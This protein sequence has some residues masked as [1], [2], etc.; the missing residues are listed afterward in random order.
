VR[1]FAPQ[2]FAQLFCIPLVLFSISNSSAQIPKRASTQEQIQNREWALASLRRD[3]NAPQPAQQKLLTLRNDFRK[4]QVVNNELMAHMF[5]P[6]APQITQKEIRSSLDEIRRVAERLRSNFGLPRI[7]A[8]EPA[9]TLE[10]KPGLLQLDKAVVSFVEN[11]LFEQTKV[12]D[13]ELAM[14]AA[15]DLSEVSRLAEALRKLAGDQRMS[16]VATAR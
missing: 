11:P 6:A 2:L 4:L 13:T 16:S 12:Y 1:R 5:G 7:K 10:L 15:K 9:N 14:R 8:D 3:V